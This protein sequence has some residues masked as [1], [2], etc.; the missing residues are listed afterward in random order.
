MCDSNDGSLGSLDAGPGGEVAGE[1]AGVEHHA[2]HQ[3]GQAEL[4][5][6]PVV[7]RDPLPP[8]LPAVHPLALLCEALPPDR[9]LGAEQIL[10]GGKPV[11]SREEDG[12]AEGGAA[13]SVELCP[14]WRP[15]Q[16]SHQEVTR[17]S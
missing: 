12:G 7:P 10:R 13:Q 11:V 16:P 14:L 15:G 4:D 5:Q 8:R 3:A 9:R 2:V 1:E 17:R 6:T